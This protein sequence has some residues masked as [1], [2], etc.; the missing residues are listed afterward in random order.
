MI[1]L[2]N[3]NENVL[4]SNCSTKPSLRKKDFKMKTESASHG[5]KGKREYLTDFETKTLLNEVNKFFETRVEHA[6]Q[7]SGGRGVISLSVHGF[8]FGG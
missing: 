8:G 1:V 7:E 3:A 2:L 6:Q 5:N 4:K